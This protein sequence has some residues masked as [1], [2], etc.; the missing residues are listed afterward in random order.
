MAHTYP[1]ICINIQINKCNSKFIQ[2]IKPNLTGLSEFTFF[3]HFINKYLEGEKKGRGKYLMN[4]ANY[5]A[6]NIL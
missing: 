6:K 2:N 3:E 5:N 4:N 1:Q